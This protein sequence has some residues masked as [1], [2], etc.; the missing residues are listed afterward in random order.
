MRDMVLHIRKQVSQMMYIIIPQGV[1]IGV[2]YLSEILNYTLHSLSLRF[3]GYFLLVNSIP[4]LDN[5]GKIHHNSHERGDVLLGI[6]SGFL[7]SRGSLGLPVSVGGGSQRARSYRF[8]IQDS[9][10]NLYH[11]FILNF[12]FWI[13]HHTASM[14][15][16]DDRVFH[17]NWWGLTTGMFW[18]FF[19]S[20]IKYIYFYF[21]G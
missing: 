13:F 15:D 2:F 3:W 18:I 5:M 8:R 19:T 20:W 21:F 1:C 6:C 11:Y 9:R 17:T 4:Y 7:L 16:G 12:S 14:E 10:F